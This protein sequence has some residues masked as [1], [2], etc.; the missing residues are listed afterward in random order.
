MQSDRLFICSLVIVTEKSNSCMVG[1]KE[2][3]YNIKY[4]YITEKI[5]C[6]K[7]DRFYDIENLKYSYQ[8]LEKE[9]SLTR[10]G[11]IYI[12]PETI[13]S[14]CEVAKNNGIDLKSKLNRKQS[15]KTYNLIK[16][17]QSK[18]EHKVLRLIK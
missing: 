1:P 9:S 16:E 5:L 17:K 11:E 18:K 3:P 13:K 14:L 8:I 12:L 10:I 4:E 6:K 15:Q 2:N 7:D